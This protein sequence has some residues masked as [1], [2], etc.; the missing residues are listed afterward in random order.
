M[1]EETLL[2]QGTTLEIM[3]QVG[4]KEESGRK[5]GS[6]NF[7]SPIWTSYFDGSKSQE[8]L[9]AGCILIDR[10]GKP[11]FLSYRLEFECTNNTTEYEALV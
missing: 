1:T 2:C 5:R 9:G 6:N 10:K 7:L 8:G 11:H 3:E 4:G